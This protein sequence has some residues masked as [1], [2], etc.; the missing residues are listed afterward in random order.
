M[1]YNKIFYLLF[2]LAMI[3]CLAQVTFVIHQYPEKTIDKE[4]FI[5]GN[6]D[7]WSGG[8]D[9]RLN[10][11]ENGHL[12]ITLPK[13]KFQLEYKFTQGS[14]DTVETA[15]DGSDI[16]NRIYVF[17]KEKD[18]VLLKIEGWKNK[19]LKQPHT[20]TNNVILLTEGIANDPSNL[21]NRK[22]WAYLPPDYHK[23]SKDYRVIYMHDGQNLFDAQTSFSGEWQVDELM[24]ELYESHQLEAIVIGID[25]GGEKRID[26]YTPWVN[27]K[28]GGGKADEYLD[29]IITQVMPIVEKDLRVKKGSENTAIMGSSL[30]GLVSYYAA[31]QRPDQF[32][33]IG[34]FSPSFWYSEE[35]SAFTSLNGNIKNQ[36]MYFMASYKEDPDARTVKDSEVTIK[37]L[38]AAGYPEKNIQSKFVQEGNHNEL[39][40][41][42][43]FKEAV[44][45]LF[46]N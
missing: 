39:L 6:F 11:T 32:G 12:I 37:N 5:T 4:V 15:I 24:N 45:W 10:K 26:E 29:F 35:I 19:N 38:M 2:Q 3:P 36:K 42:Q 25:N 46:K 31:L 27:K 40:W 43:E 30:G 41:K 16:E 18:T 44:L 13:F 21:K 8:K 1:K 17:Q 23:N 7:G 20:K 22:I 9:F 28:Y 14:W 33:K 34:V